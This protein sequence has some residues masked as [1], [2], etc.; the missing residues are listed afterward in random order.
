[1]K[2]NPGQDIASY[3]ELC[4][5]DALTISRKRAKKEKSKSVAIKRESG[6][7][8][9]LEKSVKDNISV[10]VLLEAEGYITDVLS[11]CY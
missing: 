11:D 1:M 8:S 6:L 2:K 10:S 5:K 7:L 9:I 3:I 4:L